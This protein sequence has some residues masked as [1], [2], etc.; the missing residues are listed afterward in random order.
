LVA[1]AFLL[2]LCKKSRKSDGKLLNRGIDMDAQ[3]KFEAL[4]AG[5]AV[6]AWLVIVA[7]LSISQLYGSG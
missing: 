5:S 7:F 3:R 1:S 6:M 2:L 4:C